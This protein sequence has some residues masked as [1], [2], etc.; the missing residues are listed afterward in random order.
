[1][2]IASGMKKMLVT[3]LLV[4]AATID[5]RAAN[6]ANYKTINYEM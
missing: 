5:C 6:T 3:A 1:M 2:T 4:F